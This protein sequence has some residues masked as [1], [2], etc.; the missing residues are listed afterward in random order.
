MR[1]PQ[2]NSFPYVGSIISKDEEIGEDVEHR[3]KAGWL[4][5]RHTLGVFCDRRMPTR[6]KG[7]F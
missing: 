7:K 2:S 6:L 4:K 3:I 1:L 5:W